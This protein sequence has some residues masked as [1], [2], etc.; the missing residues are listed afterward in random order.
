MTTSAAVKAGIAYVPSNRKENAIIPD[1]SVLLNGTL[2]TLERVATAGIVSQKTQRGMFEKY[3]AP[4]RLKCAD[5]DN[6]ITTLS[7]GNQQKVILARWLS[8]S[9]KVLILDNPTQGVDIGAKQEIYGIIRQIAATGIAVIVLS[10][11]GQEIQRLCHRA[12]VLFH[13]KIAGELQKGTI[14]EQ[15]IM[16]LATGAGG[17]IPDVKQESSPAEHFMDNH[18]NA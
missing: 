18:T 6:L 11:E 3:V 4:L 14:T 12:F 17:K 16:R 2:A 9:P 8:A 10:G 15:D 13:G 1:M 5:S 7:G